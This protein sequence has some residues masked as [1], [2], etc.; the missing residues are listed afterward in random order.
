MAKVLRITMTW[1]AM[2]TALSV[3]GASV[4]ANADEASHWSNQRTG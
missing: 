4:P 2:M 1:L 3:V